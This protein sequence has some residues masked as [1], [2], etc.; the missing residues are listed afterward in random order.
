MRGD[1]MNFIE[2]HHNEHTRLIAID[3]IACIKQYSD[4]T[5]VFM[6]GSERGIYVDESYEQIKNKLQEAGFIWSV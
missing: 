3:N 6:I 4:E 1:F 2:L 5:G